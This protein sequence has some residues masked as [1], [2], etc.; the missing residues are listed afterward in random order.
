MRFLGFCG[1]SGFGFCGFS[2]I[3][4]FLG[5]VAFAGFL[6]FCTLMFCVFDFV[7]LGF[8]NFGVGI[9]H[10][11]GIF[12]VLGFQDFGFEFCFVLFCEL[13]VGLDLFVIVVFLVLVWVYVFCFVC[14]NLGILVGGVFG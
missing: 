12:R 3:C 10:K 2:G 4:G 11:F 5:F 1:F 14:L 9:R 7:F 13:V 8:A 6:G